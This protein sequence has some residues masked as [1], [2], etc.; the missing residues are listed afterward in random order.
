MTNDYEPRCI[1]VGV[2][3]IR[4]L[5]EGCWREDTGTGLLS[6]PLLLRKYLPCV[7]QTD[8]ATRHLSIARSHSPLL[9]FPTLPTNCPWKATVAMCINPIKRTIPTGY[10][11]VSE[12]LLCETLLYPWV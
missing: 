9:S 8:G 4:L 11:G 12:S 10:L 1:K 6:I 7:H 3:F 2:I 5:S